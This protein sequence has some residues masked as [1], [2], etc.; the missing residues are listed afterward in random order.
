MAFESS[1]SNLVTGDTNGVVDV[2]VH[3]RLTGETTRVSVSTDGAEGDADSY[4]PS[5]S[6]DGRF[7]AFQS[8]ASN[9][10]TGDTNGSGDI[11]V[12]DRDVSGS[13]IF[14]TSGNIQTTRV[15]VSTDGAE[16]D[17]DSYSPSISADGRYVAFESSASNLVTG[18]TN[19]Y[20]YY[21]DWYPASDIFVRDRLTGATTRVSVSSLGVQAGNN[22]YSPSISADG[23]H[24]AFYSDASN[25]VDGDT[26]GS[27]DIFVHDRLTSVTTRVSVSTAGIEGNQS[28]EEPSI[29]ISADGRFVAFE[30]SATNLVDGGTN[31]WTHI[32]VRDTCFGAPSECIPG[33]T[34][35]SVENT[36]TQGD[37]DSFAPSISADG[38]YVAFTSYAPNLVPGDLSDAGDIFVRDTCF[39]APAGCIPGT[40][41]VSVS[42][43]GVEGDNDSHDASIS[44][45]GRYVGFTSDATNLVAGDNNF[46]SDVFVRD[47]NPGLPFPPAVVTQAASVSL[48]GATLN[49]TVN[50]NGSATTA[51]FEYG[52]SPN[53]VTFSSVG[54]P[55][56]DSDNVIHAVSVPLTGL[57][58]GTRYY[59]RVVAGNPGGTMRGTVQYFFY[60]SGSDTTPPTVGFGAPGAGGTGVGLDNTIG[61]TFS[62]AIDCSTVTFDSFSVRTSSGFVLGDLG[63]SDGGSTVTFTP[64]AN[65]LPATAYTVT[66]AGGSGGV[67]DLAGNPMAAD[68]TWEFTTGTTPLGAPGSMVAIDA[69]GWHS[70]AL[71]GDG[72]VWSWGA[73]WSGQLG[74]GSTSGGIVVPVGTVGPGGT[75][76]LDN[77]VVVSGGY[78]HS[79]ALLSDGTVRAW[80][81]NESGQLGDNTIVDRS[82]PVQVVGPGGGV[83]DNVVAVSAGDSHSLALLSDGTVRAWGANWA[84]QLGDNTNNDNSLPVQV[85]GPGGVGF[86]DN[87]V[88]VS[89]GGGHSLALLS[90]GTVRAWGNNSSGQLGYGMFNSSTPVQV[91]GYD[92]GEFLDNVVSVSAGAYHSLALLSDGTVRAWGYNGDGQLGDGTGN[93]SSSPVRVVG[94]DGRGVLNNVVAVSAGSYHSLALLSDGTVR[95]W[96]YNGYGQLGDGTN[97]TRTSRVPVV[98]PGGGVLDNVVAV[99]A[100]D[101]HSLALLSDGTV[102]AWG[103]NGDGQLGDGTNS[104]RNVPAPISPPG[105]V[106]LNFV[107]STDPASGATGVP[108]DNTIRVTFSRQMESATINGDTFE[109]CSG[110]GEGFHCESG[111]FQYDGPANT[112]V[113][114]PGSALEGSTL[115][116]A[117]VH[118]GASGV[119]DAGGHH[120]IIDY[121]WSFTTRMSAPTV[122]GTSPVDLATGVPVSRPITATFEPGDGPSDDRQQ[123]LHDLGRRN[124]RSGDRFRE[125]NRRNLYP[126]GQSRQFHRVHSLDRNGSGERRRN[127]S[128]G[129]LHLD[130]PDRGRGTWQLERNVSRQCPLG[131]GVAHGGMDRLHHDRLGRNGHFIH[132]SEHGRPVRSDNRFLAGDLDLRGAL[133]ADLSLGRLDRHRDD[134]MGRG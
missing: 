21:G 42:T 109:L 94:F 16:G 100:G 26:N 22:S 24:V 74:V 95:A 10:V 89:A 79:L 38:R 103:A 112:M 32:F 105:L 17:T 130:L 108:V 43:G 41:R 54:S 9:L 20:W 27:G 125:R 31:G 97:N 134:R 122:D 96:G 28:S 116:S 57:T 60:T 114:T 34:L 102:W 4:S 98:G 80:G 14:D 81:T 117:R 111:T 129:P 84:G 66:V 55:F 62:E 71:S 6:A 82:S 50:P 61:A 12:H 51:W 86:L 44:A 133:G 77:V 93:S 118:G 73:N 23:R 35:V 53:L 119:A 104:D 83:L 121:T 25:L 87:V 39:G 48:A 123:R 99:S 40:T 126:D 115:Y 110:T 113:F 30:S 72:H 132:A 131:Q 88:A 49:G 76:T 70:L 2:F 67:K 85:V 69:G 36:G 64:W 29:S 127:A 37:N 13:G 7:V 46:V 15:S 124:T 45:D 65:L 90:D 33:T 5:I 8:Y 75:G 19:G 101:S 1:A 56:V 58:P 91:V 78:L 107:L 120:M 106:P 92:G 52:T 63:C 3:D 47:T 59:Y 68:Y 18:D 128:R 11:F